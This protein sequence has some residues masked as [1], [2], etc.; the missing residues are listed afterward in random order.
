M[1]F[2]TIKNVMLIDDS[3]VDNFVNQRIIQKHGL[4]CSFVIKQSA[5]EAL[6]HLM[7]SHKNNEPFP[8][9]I[10]L[11]IHMPEMNGFEFLDAFHEH[12]GE[13]DHNCQIFLLSSTL[14]PK[15]IKRGAEDPNV[16]KILTKPLKMSDLET[17]L[18]L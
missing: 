6:T 11:D 12:F 3:D 16:H 1:Y 10:F 14:D 2:Q 13:L 4:S 9:L 7:H 5:N 15:D 18:P 8:D 17:H